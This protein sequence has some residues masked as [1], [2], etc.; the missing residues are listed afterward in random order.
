MEVL[1]MSESS[2]SDRRSQVKVEPELWE[3]PLK[4]R[5]FSYYWTPTI[6]GKTV[7]V[8]L[9]GARNRT[10]AKEMK[11]RKECERARREMVAPSERLFANLARD[12]L[13]AQ[14]AKT[15]HREHPLQQSTVDLYEDDYKRDLVYF[16]RFGRVDKITTS[17]IETWLADLKTRVGHSTQKRLV[18][19]LRR[20]LA[21]HVREHGGISPLDGVDPDALPKRKK[22]SRKRVS[23]PKPDGIYGFL[24]AAD[25]RYRLA[26]TIIAFT[27]LRVSEALGLR[28]CDIDFDENTITVRHQFYRGVFKD[29]AK[30]PAGDDRVIPMLPFVREELVIAQAVAEDA[31]RGGEGDRVLLD[32]DGVPLTGDQILKHGVYKTATATG[33]DGL[34]T[35][36]LRHWFVST[37]TWAGVP[38]NVIKD[39][40]GHETNDADDVTTIYTHAYSREETFAMVLERCAAINFGNAREEIPA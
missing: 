29:S 1:V 28:W 31:G 17:E 2:Q 30:T 20:I 10:Q 21:R 15:L 16:E 37:L 3:R 25:A 22:G 6:D 39:I 12:W 33:H 4:S 38:R 11:R 14:Q 40:V 8:L 24:A 18:G 23:I 26:L 35:H 27:G 19:L 34:T 32:E 36:T 9:K 13:D 7:W 5:R